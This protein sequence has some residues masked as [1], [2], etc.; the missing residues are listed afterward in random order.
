MTD[1]I[2]HSGHL[3]RWLLLRGYADR[4]DINAPIIMI[5]NNIILNRGEN[6]L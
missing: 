3:K 5:M 4:Y 6:I 1:S 2:K